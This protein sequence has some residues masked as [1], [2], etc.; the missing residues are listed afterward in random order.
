MDLNQQLA[1]ISRAVEK[2]TLESGDEG[3]IIT[4]S[5]TFDI[6]VSSL[7]ETCTKP[8]KI[9]QF[10]S[11][12]SGDL[13]VNGRFQVENNA[14]GTIE[15]CIPPSNFRVSW[16]FGDSTSWVEVRISQVSET[17]SRLE[18]SHT[19]PVNK[20]WE[21]YGAGAGGVGWEM[22]FAGLAYHLKGVKVGPEW[23]GQDETKTYLAKCSE[24]WGE[25][26]V[27][28]GEDPEVVKQRVERTTKF[29]VPG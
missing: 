18:L 13:F 9:K 25:A 4:I 17:Q 26:T 24:A 27:L 8:D 29:Y 20:H 14:S 3:R 21:E 11:P 22:S 7:W 16:E 2:M 19:A 12:V 6:D 5:Q 15:K 28:G 1:A 10:F 23:F